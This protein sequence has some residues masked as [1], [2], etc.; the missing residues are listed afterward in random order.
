MIDRRQFLKNCAAGVG[1]MAVADLMGAELHHP[2]K[3]KSV[4]FLY[5]PGGPS[6]IDLFDPKP[7]LTK[8]HGKP[9]P[10]SL[11]KGLKLALIK[12]NANAVASPRVFERHG[13]SGIEI[14]DWLPNLARSADRMCMLR[15]VHSEAFNHDPG[16]MFLMTGHTQ[17]GRPSMGSW[18]LYGLGSESKN[19]PGFVVLT[20]GTPPSAG[21]NNWSAG[22]LPSAFQGTPF[23]GSGE[24]I[25]FLTSPSG[26]DEP[27]QRVRLDA[28]GALNRRRLEAT[29]DPEIEARISSYELAF[30]MQ[31]AA[32]ELLD[33]SKESAATL[34]CYGVNREPTRT[35]ATN[36]LLARRMVERGVRFVLVSHGNWDDHNDL[37]KNLKKNCEITDRPAAA[38]L[39]DLAGRG[40]LDSTLV[41]WGGEFGRTPMTQQQR[42]DIG[43]GRDHHPNCFS[44]WLAGGGVRAGQVIGRT[45]EFGLQGVEDRVSVH[46]LQA[47]ILHLLGLDHTRL[48]YSHMGRKFRLTDVHGEVVKKVLRSS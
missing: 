27:M 37:D 11:T 24:P 30:R 44:M 46:D 23:R 36:C 47:T 21:A 9:L 34:E 28:I 41:I 45:D 33:L 25:P 43:Y 15:S 10:E 22:F 29:G 32:P 13:Q 42:F 5:M 14:S 16:E 31:S 19:L 1:M 48:T 40:L 17:F 35:Y 7:E 38:L 4:I 18:A 12:P 26:Y 20:S 8:W 2:A 3:A 39:E 6:Q